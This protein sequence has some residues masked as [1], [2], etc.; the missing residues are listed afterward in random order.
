MVWPQMP[1]ASEWKMASRPIKTTT[2]ESTGALCSGRRMIRSMLTPMRNEISA[3][4]GN[5]IQKL[6]PHCMSCQQ[7]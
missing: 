2:M 6:S 4:T 1:P 7:I 5:A 3:T